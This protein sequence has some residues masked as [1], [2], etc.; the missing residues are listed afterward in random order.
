MNDYA[1]VHQMDYLDVNEP[2]TSAG[3]A[4][5]PAAMAWLARLTAC[6]CFQGC[7]DCPITLTL[8]ARLHCQSKQM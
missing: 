2:F 1:L 4:K 6:A 7:C 5:I 8:I 3:L